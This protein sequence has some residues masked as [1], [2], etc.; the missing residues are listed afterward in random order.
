MKKIIYLTLCALLTLTGCVHKDLGDFARPASVR[1]VFDWKK[2]PEAK[3][4]SMTLY[5]FPIGGEGLSP[6]EFTDYRGG[7]IAVAPGRYKV[8][9]FNSDTETILCNEDSSFD[10][11]ELYSTSTAVSLR[12]IP[13]PRIGGTENQRMVNSPE[14]IY[15]DR[16]EEVEIRYAEGEVQVITLYPE[17][18]VCRYTVVIHNVE[19]LQYVAQSDIIG[20]LSGLAGGFFPGLNQPA[21]PEVTIPFTPAC[22]KEQNT[23]NATFLTFGTPPPPG[24]KHLLTICAILS[25]GQKL[26]FPFDVGAIIDNAPD[27]QEVLIELDGLPFP[28][29]I[30]NG[31]G[32]HPEVQD[33][34]DVK[35]DLQM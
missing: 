35:I 16:L 21:P 34:Q 5:L 30:V 9:C 31:S 22:N 28:K 2:A 10:R 26:Y 23:L 20:T 3:P 15:T 13:V 11:F 8:L 32:F 14:R 6:H 4:K 18:S 24:R 25:D 7:Q 19:N 12:S 17:L 27:P 33:W 29:P 1:V